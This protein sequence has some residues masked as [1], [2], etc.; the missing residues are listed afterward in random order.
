MCK[1]FSPNYDKISK[2]TTGDIGIAEKLNNL[3]MLDIISSAPELEDKIK[4]NM[5]LIPGFGLNAL[6]KTIISSMMESLGPITKLSEGLLELMSGVEYAVVK[7][8]GGIDP[9]GIDGSFTNMLN[10][11]GIKKYPTKIFL[12]KTNLKQESVSPTKADLNGYSYYN[13]WPY[14]LDEGSLITTNLKLNDKYLNT[15]NTEDKESNTNIIINNS[16]IDFNNYSQKRTDLLKPV[17]VKHKIKYNSNDISIDPEKTYN[18]TFKQDGDYLLYYADMND[19]KKSSS[20]YMSIDLLAVPG[21]ISDKVI[22]PI[23]DK[24]TD[25][26]ITCENIISKPV[27]FL[28]EIINIKLKEHCKFLGIKND[29]NNTLHKLIYSGEK[30]LID[31]FSSINLLNFKFGLG[32]KNG[33]VSSEEQNTE[34]PF[35]STILNFIKLPIEIIVG[36]VKVIKKML[37][38]IIDPTKIL[39]TFNDFITFK[40]LTDLLSIDKLYSFLGATDGTYKTI[41]FFKNNLKDSFLIKALKSLLQLVQE[42]FNAFIGIIEAIFCIPIPQIKLV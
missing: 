29:T 36:I 28:T 31:G 10:K 24:I 12:L 3:A 6:E 35:M 27:D 34:Q 16:K 15:L 25:A 39:D 23:Q 42:F 20:G 7:I 18:I 1:G 5:Q 2:Y 26:I 40:W 30:C 9:S 22:S 8:I 41:P 4:Q 32:I 21:I 11:K 37:G 17:F 19:D 33:D 38:T 13:K 14:V